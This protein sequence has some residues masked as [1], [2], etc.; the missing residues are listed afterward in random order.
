MDLRRKVTRRVKN[1]SGFLLADE[2]NFI[3]FFPFFY[4][5][6]FI[7]GYLGQMDFLFTRNASFLVAM[8][9]LVA[10]KITGTVPEVIKLRA[11]RLSV[12]ENKCRIDLRAYSACDR[13]REIH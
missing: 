9:W 11:F 13:C 10:A 12:R 8:K 3:L 2:P 5:A 6:V 4:V 7:Y 1:K